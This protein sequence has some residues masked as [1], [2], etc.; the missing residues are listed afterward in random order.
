MSPMRSLGLTA[1][2][3]SLA[4]GGCRQIQDS[5][6]YH[7]VAAP[8]TPPMPPRGWSVETLVLPRPDAV[9]LRGWLVRP[10]G[11]AAPLLVYFGGNG[12]E[13]SWQVP[14]AD[15]LGDRALAGVNYRGY[16]QSSGRPSESALLADAVALVEHLQSR[17]DV[18]GARVA[19]M[20]RSL[21]SGVAVHVAS[22]VA[23]ERVVLVSP[24]DSIAAVAASHFPAALVRIVLSDRYDA[25]ALAPRSDAPLLAV[26]AGRDDI[27]PL[28]HSQRLFAAWRGEKHWLEVARAG[29][30]DLQEYPEYWQAIAAFL[31]PAPR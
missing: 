3:V 2:V 17:S 15:R 10:P 30:N 19:L 21:G 24:Y 23:V 14:V 22:R 25:I 27:I 12:E 26:A 6:L 16:G 4:V 8:G 20:G 9:E 31:A 5:L 18:D 13:V 29:H 28:A 1:L 11:S 7:P